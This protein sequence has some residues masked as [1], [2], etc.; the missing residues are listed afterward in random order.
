MER[1][2]L[3]GI[4]R[5]I[6]DDLTTCRIFRTL[7]EDLSFSEDEHT[8]L[9]MRQEVNL[10]KPEEM[11]LRWDEPPDNPG[12]PKEIAIGPKATEII[13]AA[14]AIADEEKVLTAEHV[15]L[16]DKFAPPADPEVPPA[17]A[18]KPAL[19]LVE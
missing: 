14:F 10:K 17:P 11:A 4:L 19:A 16:Y 9:K 1:L 12:C 13:V 2:M 15:P 6:K 5:P 3:L 7:R 18:E 8:A